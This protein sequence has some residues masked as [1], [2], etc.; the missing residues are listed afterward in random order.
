MKAEHHR[1]SHQVNARKV[2][3]LAT[4]NPLTLCWSCKRP[5]QAHPPHTNGDPARWTGGHTVRGSTTATPWL[6]PMVSPTDCATAATG[7]W[8]APEASVCNYADRDNNPNHITT[9]RRW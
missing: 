7:D 6:R 4:A 2:C 1:G 5:L 8:L 3:D 9:T